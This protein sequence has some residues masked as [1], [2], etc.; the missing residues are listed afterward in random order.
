MNKKIPEEKSE[1]KL[2]FS[3][4]KKTVSEDKIAAH[5]QKIAAKLLDEEVSSA[6]NSEKKNK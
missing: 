4:Q 3:F 1:E 6:R 5:W 2:P